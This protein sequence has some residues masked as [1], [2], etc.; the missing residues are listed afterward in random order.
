MN[1]R[2]SLQRTRNSGSDGT[3]RTSASSSRL[4]QP[5][6]A[7]IHDRILLALRLY[8]EAQWP[9]LTVMM[10]DRVQTVFRQRRK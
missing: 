8:P 7:M 6:L 5:S 2:F 4:R 10:R 1:E 9:G 3:S